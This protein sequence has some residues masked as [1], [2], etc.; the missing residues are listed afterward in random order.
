MDLY[1]ER[2]MSKPTLAGIK[3]SSL[4]DESEDEEEAR[5][6]LEMREQQDLKLGKGQ[7]GKLGDPGDSRA[8]GSTARSDDDEKAKDINA[9]GKKPTSSAAGTV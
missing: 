7:N 1:G 8:E 5:E 3:V 4:V 6:K 2:M 9:D